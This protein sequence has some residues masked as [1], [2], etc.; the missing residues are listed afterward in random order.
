MISAISNQHARFFAVQ[1]RAVAR[2]ASIDRYRS[3]IRQ[4][5]RRTTE[6]DLAKATGI[7]QGFLSEIESEQEPGTP[8]TLKKIAQALNIKINDL[9]P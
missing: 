6:A 4:Q 1:S 8:A 2:A 9:I 5:I 7:A 3:T